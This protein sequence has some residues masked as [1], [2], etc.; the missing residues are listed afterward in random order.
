[1]GWTCVFQPYLQCI[2]WLFLLRCF[3]LKSGGRTIREDPFFR[4]VSLLSSLLRSSAK[5]QFL[6]TA[7]VVAIA[8]GDVTGDEIAVLYPIP[9]V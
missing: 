5:D 4:W 6:K 2:V 3:E 7:L 1:M 9:N 8:I